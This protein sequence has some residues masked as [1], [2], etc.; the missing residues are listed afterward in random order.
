MSNPELQ[1][2]IIEK[3]NEISE[4]YENREFSKVIR[5]VM[6][7]ADIINQYID[8]TKPW[9]KERTPEERKN[10]NDAFTANT[11]FQRS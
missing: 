1:N 9:V 3:N 5:I 2:S 8:E 11:D 7:L 6:S 10:Y 4:A